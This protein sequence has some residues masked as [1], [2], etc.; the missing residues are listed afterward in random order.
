MVEKREKF[1]SGTGFI[2]ACTG[3]AVGMGNIWMFPWRLGQ[4]GG[5]A[6]LVPYLIFVIGLGMTGLMCEYG[7]GRWAGK[8]AVGAFDKILRLRGLRFGRLLGAYPVL[9]ASCVFIF[10]A[11][12]TGWV[13]KYIYASTTGAY[14]SGVSRGVYFD[15]LAGH[16]DSI[17]WQLLAII[18]T[19]LIVVFG[20]IKGIERVNNMIMPV[21]LVLFLILLVR[22]L[23]L[24]GAMKG[25]NY[26]LN[27]DWSFLLKPSTWGMAL[28][29][30][31][32]TV[33]LGGAAMLVY[34]SYLGQD[35]DIP[36][37]AVSTVI[38]DTLGALL[39]ALVIIPAIFAYGFDLAAG[40]QLL[41]IT[42]PEIF[43]TMPGGQLFSVMFFTGVLF[44]AL[45]SLINIMEIIVESLIDQFQWTRRTAVGI[46]A[47][48]GFTCGIP[49]AIDMSLFTKFVDIVTVYFTPLGAAMAA[50]L[51]FWI[52]PIE[53]ARLAINS[54]AQYPV[55]SWWNPVAKYGYVGVAILVVLLQI[56]YRIG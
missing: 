16:P 51:F 35:A 32:F 17:Y 43:S 25:I 30:A 20:I 50:F 5:A 3:A 14:L 52:N 11:I 47:I 36:F 23:T 2:L 29:Q 55:G 49:L 18:I 33:S 9:N 54:G 24:P 10:Y 6:F 8:G 39:S 37:S 12:V 1:S 13:L 28:G 27:P 45:S 42:L 56:F 34:G 7:L 48:S 53:K 46:V 31:F 40:P 38:L 4:Y 44:A 21:L 22:S 41:F 15:A 19:G 26:L